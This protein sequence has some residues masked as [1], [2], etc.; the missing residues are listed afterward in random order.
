MTQR[1]GFG[2]FKREVRGIPPDNR[3]P[4]PDGMVQ[5]GSYRASFGHFAIAAVEYRIRS[6]YGAPGGGGRGAARRKRRVQHGIEHGKPTLDRLI[7][8]D[9]GYKD[10]TGA[11]RGDISGSHPFGLVAPQLLVCRF[12]EL[13]G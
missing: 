11:G 8:A 9:R 3:R 13:D 5:A 12:K 6:K 2:Y 1:Q 10:I 4:V 7:A